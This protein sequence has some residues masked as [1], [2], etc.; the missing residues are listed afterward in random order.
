MNDKSEFYA[1]KV[2]SESISNDSVNRL[3]FKFAK[4]C[5]IP[6]TFEFE[7]HHLPSI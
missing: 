4:N 5:Q 3:D 1:I 6:T 7:L 2:K